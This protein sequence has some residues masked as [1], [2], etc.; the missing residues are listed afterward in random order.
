MDW[1]KRGI[2][3]LDVG[4][5]VSCLVA[6]ALA[7]SMMFRPRSSVERDPEPGLAFMR[8]FGQSLAIYSEANDS[9]RIT[10]FAHLPDSAFPNG[11]DGF[12][13]GSDPTPTGWANYLRG[14]RHPAYAISH[15]PLRTRF[16]SVIDL[17]SIT[18]GAIYFSHRG[19]WEPNPRFESAVM[20]GTTAAILPDLCL[21][22]RVATHEPMDLCEGSYVRL[23]IDSSVARG[24]LRTHKLSAPNPYAAW[25]SPRR[26]GDAMDWVE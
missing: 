16:E 24:E 1:M 11:A 26:M 25:T 21:W 12:R 4:V 8:Q 5:A 13:F 20:F 19:V 3:L 18:G 17:E 22:Q 9:V 14:S 7:F 2:S 15:P 10:D 6:L 23:R